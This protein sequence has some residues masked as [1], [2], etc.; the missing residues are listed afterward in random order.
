MTPHGDEDAALAALSAAYLHLLDDLAR[1]HL[2]GDWI[3]EHLR[4]ILDGGP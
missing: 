3:E 2:T 4:Q 1:C